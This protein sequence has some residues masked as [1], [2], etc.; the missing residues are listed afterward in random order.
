M[1]QASPDQV[2]LTSAQVRARYG[3]V[4]DMWI[5]RRILTDAEFPRPTYYGRRRFWRIDE[6]DAYDL[7]K[8]RRSAL[9]SSAV[10]TEDAVCQP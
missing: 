6:L 4:S 1:S 10:K 2:F 7:K 5:H 3:G 9:K 8:A